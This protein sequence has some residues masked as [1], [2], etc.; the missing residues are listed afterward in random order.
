MRNT[1]KEGNQEQEI[2]PRIMKMAAKLRKMRIEKGFSN[3][4]YF[5]WDNEINRVQY[6]KVE[7]GTNMTMKTLL[8]I[9][10]I[11]GISLAE[12]FKDM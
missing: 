7:K 1:K 10:D 2:D 9:L 6:W 11:H 5:A 8:K 4:E 3:Y 12:F